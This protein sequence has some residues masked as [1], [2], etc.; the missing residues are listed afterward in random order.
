[1]VPD[2]VEEDFNVIE[3]INAYSASSHESV[4]FIDQPITLWVLR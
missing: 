4:G 3:D 2:P 1:M